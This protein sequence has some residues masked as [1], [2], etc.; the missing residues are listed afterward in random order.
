MRGITAGPLIYPSTNPKYTFA[1]VLTTAG[2][3]A[4]ISAFFFNV[5]FIG[6]ALVAGLIIERASRRLIFSFAIVG[7][8]ACVIGMGFGQDYK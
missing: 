8:S 6:F 3:R 1:G 4:N 2:E 7:V 5:T